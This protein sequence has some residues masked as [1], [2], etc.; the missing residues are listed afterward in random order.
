MSS[1]LKK[2]LGGGEPA[3]ITPA[4]PAA[5]RVYEVGN[6]AGLPIRLVKAQSKAQAVSHVVDG[7]FSAEVPS[8]DRLIELVTQGCVVEDWHRA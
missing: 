7:T 2:I 4:V 6:S 5:R 1:I 8:Q 3:P